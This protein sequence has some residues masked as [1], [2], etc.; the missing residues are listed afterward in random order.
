MR[1]AGR[2]TQTLPNSPSKHLTIATRH[3]EGLNEQQQNGVSPFNLR[4]D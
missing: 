3:S 1:T 2:Y 4:R